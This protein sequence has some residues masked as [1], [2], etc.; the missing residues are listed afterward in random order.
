MYDIRIRE[1]GCPDIDDRGDFVPVNFARYIEQKIYGALMS[2]STDL[3]SSVPANRHSEIEANISDYL[4]GF[5][6]G[7]SD[8][9][10]SGIAITVTPVPGSERITMS[11]AYEGT[12]PTGETVEYEGDLQY[13][14][15][16]G[17]MLSV[18]Y[19]PIWLT[20]S[21]IDTEKDLVFPISIQEVTNRVEIPLEPVAGIGSSDNVK[22]G[23]SQH[24]IYLMT[25]S[26]VEGSSQLTES[27]FTIQFYQGRSKYPIS[28]YITNFQ[29]RENVI[30][31]YEFTN[32]A[33]APEFY[34][35]TKYGEPVI[36]VDQGGTGSVT[37]TVQIRNA[38]QATNNYTMEQELVA[39]PLFPLRR[40]RGK[41]FAVFPK[42]IQIGDYFVKYKALSEVI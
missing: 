35:I 18:D 29:R 41:Y 38:V 42:T 24:P 40:R 14:L 1:D 22:T 16:S 15:S 34:V 7:D 20:S 6:A 10:P 37:G 4:T 23:T 21:Q 8:V 3:V 11:L 9:D 32:T 33:L 31:S 12:S 13:S 25:Q 39:A 28:S 2:M 17:A 5:F 19:S 26:Q 30:Y 36:V 27:S